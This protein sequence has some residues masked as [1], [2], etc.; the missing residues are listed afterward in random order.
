MEF[1]YSNLPP[2]KTKN[3]TFT[4]VFFSL[5]QES[6]QIDIAVAYITADSLVELKKTVEYNENIE[7]LNLI[8]G[9]HRW[10]KFTKNEYNAALELNNYLCSNRRGEVRLI[11]PF[12]FHGK[13]YSYSNRGN[14]LAGIIGSNNLSS[15][16]G[17]HTRTFEASILFRE[18]E[19]ATQIKEFIEELSEK[20]ADN[21]AECEITEFKEVNLLL[22]DHDNVIKVSHD[23]KA[24]VMSSLT[25]VRFEIPLVK[26]GKVPEASNLNAF[27][28]KGREHR[29]TGVIIPRHWYEVEIIVPNEIASKPEYPKKNTPSGVFDVVTD[30]GWRFSCTVNGDYSKN[31]RS[32]DGLRIL[33]KWIKGRLENEGV[34]DI[35]QPVTAETFQKYGRESFS[36]TKTTIPNLWFLDFG[37]QG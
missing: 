29:R 13:L 14:V 16:V 34:L 23:Q 6:T 27:F 12:R 21:L 36:L 19:P 26:K 15:I 30:D 25:D 7:K 37:V 28:G 18:K 3:P 4:D 31:F 22:E 11:T 10:E 5:I 20:A 24:D 8:I 35:G 17:S 9:M 2:V 33:G 32:K 1:L